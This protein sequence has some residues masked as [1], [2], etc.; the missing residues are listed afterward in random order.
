MANHA[1]ALQQRFFLVRISLFSILVLI[2]VTVTGGE[3][4]VDFSRDVRPILSDHCFA[5]HGPDEQERQ[6]DLR[7]DTAEGLMAAVEPGNAD[8]SELIARVLSE[9]ADERMPPDEFHKPLSAEQIS[10]LQAWVNHG[11]EVTQHWSFVR[12]DKRPDAPDDPAIAIDHYIG[13]KIAAAGLVANPIADRRTLLRRVCLDLTGLP[14]TR[15]QLHQFLSDDSPDAYERLVDRLLLSP[16][17]GQ[18]VGRYWLDLVR[19]GDT[20]GLHLD[21]YREMWPYRDWVIES[22]NANMP[23][24]VF[25][26]KQL[27]GDLLPDATDADKI[28]SGFNRLNITTNEGGSIYDEV[29]ARNVIDRTDAFGTI[30]LGLSTQCAVCHDHKF[31]PITSKDY[32]SLSAFFNSLDGKAM[33]GNVKD[34]APVI[35]VPTADQ[36][37]RLAKVEQIVKDLEREMSE[38]IESVDQTQLAWQRSVIGEVAPKIEYLQPTEVVSR[39]DVE[40]AV[41]EDGSVQLVGDA[42][43][44]D[45]TTITAKLPTG[46]AWATVRI[47]AL[48]KTPDER[49]GA[50]SNGNVVL[51]EVVIETIDDESKGEWVNVPIVKAVADVEQKN[52]PFAAKFAI[53][54]KVSD[55]EGWAV[56]GHKQS[57]GRTLQLATPSLVAEAKNPQIRIKLKYRSKFAKHQF[58][59]V[60]I[61]LSDAPPTADVPPEIL[62][63]VKQASTDTVVP[64]KLRDY[65]RKEQCHHPDWLAL[66]DQLAGAKKTKEKLV[67]ESPTTLVWKELKQP[68]QA[69]ILMRGQYDQPGDPVPRDTPEFLPEFPEDAP[70]DRLGLA[71]WL[72]SP[73]HPLTARVAVNRFWQQIFGTGLV[74][75]SEDFGSQGEP[76]SHPDLLDCLA[77][78]F[79]ESGWD[80][81]RLIKAIVLSASYKRSPRTSADQQRVDPENRLLARGP[82]FRLDAEVLRDQALALAGLLVDKPGGPSVKPPQPAGL[83]KAVGY[84]GSNTVKFSPD[85][86]DKIYRRSV[87]TFW[88]RT[89]PP[90]QMSTFD[91]PSRESCTARRERTNTPLQALLLMNEQQYVEAANHLAKRVLEQSDLNTSEQRVR[92][93]FETVTCQLPS[94]LEQRE[95]GNLLRDATDHYTQKPDDADRLC[96]TTDATEAAWTIVASALLNLDQVVSK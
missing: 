83:W 15:Q 6:A 21:N 45:T 95:L 12:P 8:S 85:Q 36:R 93:L 38:P 43:D 63:L 4:S 60:R 70:N 35:T 18:H 19:Y 14:P 52:G 89:A 47:E 61:G 48:T 86:G 39:A 74:K 67:K 41:L 22:F 50:S 10:N 42:A 91:A 81:K 27:A 80:V 62:A 1:D 51:T 75:T 44:K 77:V 79:V 58:R 92:W 56:A 11:A 28:A 96:G 53:D 76:P 26:K 7:L 65:Y 17:Y 68:R 13:K 84:S 20:H 71:D 23:F 66:A 57:G 59:R 5:C 16:H 31:D 3:L 37:A 73:Q 9:D 40:M 49:V 88:K 33:D 54:Q 32:Y 55:S 29:F 87:Y 34:H 94:E 72:T 78:D 82:R 24:D 69:H 2:A 90:P 46:A 64:G 30:F 25:I